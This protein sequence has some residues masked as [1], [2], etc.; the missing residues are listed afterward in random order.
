M[1]R[2][3]R[4]AARSTRA[5]GLT[6]RRC[7]ASATPRSIACS[8]RNTGGPSPSWS[9]SSATSTS[10]RRRCR[11]RSRR[12]GSGGRHGTASK[13]GGLDH[14]DRAQPGDRPPAARGL[15]RG[16]SRHRRP[17]ACRAASRRRGRGARRSAPADLHVLP[18]G[19][20]PR[21]S[22]RADAP[23]ARRAHRRRRSRAP[24][25]SRRRPW[26][27]GSCGPRARSATPRSPTASPARQSFP[28]GSAGAGGRLPDLQ[29]GLHRELGRSARPRGSLRRGD[30]PRAAPRRPDARRARGPGASGADAARRVAPRR[31]HQPGGDLVRLADQDRALWDRG[32]VAEG[33][34]IV[35][36][37]CSATSRAPT[38]SRRRSR[39]STATRRP[40]A[41]PTGARSCSSTTS[42]SRWH[43][44]R[45]SLLNRAVALA[46]VEGATAAL[47]RSTSLDLGDYYLFHAVRADL[48]SRTGRNEEASSAYAAALVLTSNAI[49][50]TFLERARNALPT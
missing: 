22:G 12:E 7:A 41:P 27:S 3:D 33:Q 34:A 10:P 2:A 14:H 49:E 47:L 26:P 37:C 28:T 48:L 20:R 46:E 32:L 15:A 9:A 1:C 29:R 25:S 38:R 6:S 11:T 17:V 43:R 21:R 19:A 42:C 4:G 39:R 45:W 40:P 30:P 36:R 50:R 5:G 23:A 13:P 24:S 18:S 16:P 44:P 35:R 8:A 31:P